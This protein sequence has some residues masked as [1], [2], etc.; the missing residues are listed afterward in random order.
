MGGRLCHLLPRGPCMDSCVLWAATS[1][2]FSDVWLFWVGVFVICSRGVPA[3][4][5]S[6][7]P[8]IPRLAG[9]V[10][11]LHPVAGFYGVSL[12][13]WLAVCPAGSLQLLGLMSPAWFVFPGVHAVSSDWSAQ[14]GFVLHLRFCAVPL[15]QQLRLRVFGLDGFPEYRLFMLCFNWF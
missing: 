10:A 2:C 8:F 12:C 3:W 11:W 7:W 1:G 4:I 5:H 6:R 15:G 9:C 14:F 13:S